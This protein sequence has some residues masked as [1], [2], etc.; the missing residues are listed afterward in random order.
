MHELQAVLQKWGKLQQENSTTGDRKPSPRGC[1]DN[2][3]SAKFYLIL[4]PLAVR[5]LGQTK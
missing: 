2:A 3:Q 1:Q 5:Y 4:L